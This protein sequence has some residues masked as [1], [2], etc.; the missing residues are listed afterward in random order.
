MKSNKKIAKKSTSAK[1]PISQKVGSKKQIV[2]KKVTTKKAVVLKKAP[3]RTKKNIKISKS[4]F[5][6][7]KTFIVVMLLIAVVSVIIVIAP[8]MLASITSRNNVL[9]SE[10]SS[11][12]E[13]QLAMFATL[14][15]EDAATHKKINETTGVLEPIAACNGIR[16]SIDL[17]NEVTPS[18]DV[19]KCM[20]NPSD[21][22]TDLSNNMFNTEDFKGNDKITMP[23]DAIVA[24]RGLN[25]IANLMTDAINIEQGE[26]YYFNN[27]ININS[28][29]QDF[30]KNWVVAD[31]SEMTTTPVKYFGKMSAITFFNPGTHEVVISYRGTDLTDLIDWLEDGIGYGFVD[32][33]LQDKPAANYAKYIADI[34]SASEYKIYVTGHSLGG[35]LAQVGGA[36]LINYNEDGTVNS[37]NLKR[38]VYFNGMGLFPFKP[39]KIRKNPAHTE[40][41]DKFLKWN[42][43]DGVAGDKIML[44]HINGDPVSSIGVHYGQVK[45]LHASHDVAMA[46][47][48][49]Y[50]K[51]LN[52]KLAD[53]IKQA[54]GATHD[55]F[56]KIIA[57]NPEYEDM[58]IQQIIDSISWPK[59]L[60]WLITNDGSGLSLI[61]NTLKSLIGMN[62]NTKT[63]SSSWK[64]NGSGA[65]LG[66]MMTVHP[67]DN[68]FYTKT[69]SNMCMNGFLDE[70]GVVHNETCAYNATDNYTLPTQ[71]SIDDIKTDKTTAN[72]FNPYNH[73]TTCTFT[74]PTTTLQKGN[75]VTG[76]VKCNDLDGLSD[77]IDP[78]KITEEYGYSKITVGKITK[79]EGTNENEKSWD[80]ILTAKTGLEHPA[81]KTWM[82]VDKGFVE[83]IYGQKANRAFRSNQITTLN[84]R[85]RC[86]FTISPSTVKKGSSTK[87]IITCTDKDGIN[88]ASMNKSKIAEEFAHYKMSVGSVTSIPDNDATTQS[89]IVTLTAKTGLF[90][91]KGNTWMWANAGFVKDVSGTLNESVQS[92]RITTK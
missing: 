26:H 36:K 79:V 4:N 13:D 86:T 78:S 47:N 28:A 89:W 72:I 2:S 43:S 8:S 25:F 12:T 84:S 16:G 63:W 6:S 82:W 22:S 14:S 53:L 24:D 68:F 41:A 90:N 35:Y 75:S 54:Q 18:E 81:G 74:I 27:L 92:N 38:I 49:Q 76:R 55:V 46:Y 83:D 17:Y 15:Y 70:D 61:V 19:I 59:N 11:V 85:P 30:L 73:P 23:D 69:Y 48:R 52:T 33:T 34:Y 58:T 37:G 44:V 87:G 57:L 39:T 5:K 60:K 51:G 40:I 10:I 66:W 21:Y 62:I 65:F 67:T 71:A 56:L 50:V 42:T 77:E 7:F 9:S 80:V 29:K 88:N 3:T 1:K 31:F 32:N 20:T 45:T 64:E 91:L